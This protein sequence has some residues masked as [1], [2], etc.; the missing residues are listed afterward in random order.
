VAHFRVSG[1]GKILSLGFLGPAVHRP[2]LAGNE[3]LLTH[4]TQNW[5]SFAF[6]CRKVRYSRRI[7]TAIKELIERCA[8]E[9][10]ADALNAK[11]IGAQTGQNPVR[12]HAR[13]VAKSM[14]GS[15]S[16]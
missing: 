2:N 1:Q 8:Q 6:S 12:R 14:R 11:P 10:S 3:H 15:I 9:L 13:R 5:P 7:K 16:M 4:Y